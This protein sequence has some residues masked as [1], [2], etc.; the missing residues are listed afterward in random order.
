MSLILSTPQIYNKLSVSAIKIYTGVVLLFLH[1]HRCRKY[2][3]LP[4]FNDEKDAVKRN[5]HCQAFNLSVISHYQ[6]ILLK[7]I[8]S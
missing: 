8:K 4:K 2:D 6:G 5:I 1:E 3:I 7:I